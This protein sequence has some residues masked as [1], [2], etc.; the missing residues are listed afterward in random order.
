MMLLVSWW[1]FP[2]Y[3]ISFPFN[4][5]VYPYTLMTFSVE[6]FPCHTPSVYRLFFAFLVH[7]VVSWADYFELLGVNYFSGHIIY[8]PIFKNSYSEIL[9]YTRPSSTIALHNW[10]HPLAFQQGWTSSS[11]YGKKEDFLGD[12]DHHF[13]IHAMFVNNLINWQHRELGF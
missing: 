11:R 6:G 4:F 13:R 3:Y 1:W 12:F 8:T 10:F 9:K 7:Y 2:L 5:P